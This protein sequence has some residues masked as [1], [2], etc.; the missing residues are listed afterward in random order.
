MAPKEPYRQSKWADVSPL[1]KYFSGAV[2][3]HRKAPSG[4]YSASL[5]KIRTYYDA[6]KLIPYWKPNLFLYCCLRI[7]WTITNHNTPLEG[8]S[9]RKFDQ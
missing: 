6:L 7:A 5:I 9:L 8:A 4:P 2:A 1:L 3:P